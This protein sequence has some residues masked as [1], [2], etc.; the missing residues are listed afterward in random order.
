MEDYIRF[1]TNEINAA[2]TS[3]FF[4]RFYQDCTENECNNDSHDL[5]SFFRETPRA[6][7]R[8]GFYSDGIT[9]PRHVPGPGAAQTHFGKIIMKDHDEIPRSHY[10]F[11]FYMCPYNIPRGR[12][13]EDKRENSRQKMMAL[14][15]DQRL[16]WKEI[17]APEAQKAK[18]PTIRAI[19]R[20]ARIY[21][22]TLAAFIHPDVFFK[23]M[24]TL[25]MSIRYVLIHEIRHICSNDI[26]NIVDAT[27]NFTMLYFAQLPMVQYRTKFCTKKRHHVYSQVPAHKQMPSPP[28]NFI[29]EDSHPPEPKSKFYCNYVIR[30]WSLQP[31]QETENFPV[32]HKKDRY[33]A[34]F[35]HPHS[36]FYFRAQY[37]KL[38]NTMY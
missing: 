5:P 28:D 1:I 15:R 30:F 23:Q 37:Y 21:Y 19:R 3:E 14:L 4:G 9:I 22:F 13:H 24:Y 36:A 25:P 10:T 38:N 17:V 35:F 6:F 18:C 2:G 29:V 34:M 32:L 7:S 16:T 8:P 31:F 33:R 12:K 27:S 11:L 26:W 20:L